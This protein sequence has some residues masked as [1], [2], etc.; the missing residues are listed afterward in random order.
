MKVKSIAL[1]YGHTLTGAGSGA[2]GVINESIENRRLGKRVKELLEKNGVTVYDATIEKATSSSA[3]LKQAVNKANSQKV[4]LAVSIHFN[5]SSSAS[6]NGTE[7][8]IYSET[9]KAKDLAAR[10]ND[11]LVRVGFRNRGVKVYPNLYWLKTTNA[12]SILIETCFVSNIDDANLYNKKFEDVAKAIVEGILNK[13]I[14]ATNTTTT[15]ETKTETTTTKTTYRVYKDEAHIGSYSVIDNA[16]NQV[17]KLM[18]SETKNI[19]L[20]KI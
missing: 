16:L 6:A 4:D 19:R 8:L 14:T 10:V 11:K 13:S 7:T 2:V 3:Y 18:E 1:N 9:S 15:T 5:C 20:E 17:K 12:P